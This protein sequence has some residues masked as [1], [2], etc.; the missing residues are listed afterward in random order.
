MW[1]YI[2]FST[3][4]WLTAC[5]AL[6]PG[7]GTMVSGGLPQRIAIDLTSRVQY[8]PYT[9]EELARPGVQALIVQCERQ[10]WEHCRDNRTPADSRTAFGRTQ[11][12]GIFAFVTVGGLEPDRDYE[13]RFRLFAPE[14]NMR[15]QLALPM[16]AP[17]D[18]SPQT[19]LTFWFQWAPTDPATW[20]LGRWRV[21]ITINSEVVGQRTFEVMDH[22]Q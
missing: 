18:L 17:P 21:E 2:V 6:P 7:R 1:R 13:I 5:T 3:L 10:G 12:K 4:A 11:D 8:I 16:H 19:N 22:T 15:A 14:G 9:P 20:L